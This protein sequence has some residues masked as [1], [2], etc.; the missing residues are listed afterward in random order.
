M[1]FIPLKF[2]IE[3]V[4]LN[5]NQLLGILLKKTLLIILHISIPK[6]FLI[7]VDGNLVIMTLRTIGKIAPLGSSLIMNF[8]IE[9]LLMK[10]DKLFLNS[11]LKRTILL[12]KN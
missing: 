5:G 8:I 4:G 11:P 7:L 12:I 2:M 3:S 1:A 10:K 9:L 6:I